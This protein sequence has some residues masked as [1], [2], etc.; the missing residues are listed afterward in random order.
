[1]SGRCPG[2]VRLRTGPFD[3]RLLSADIDAIARTRLSRA[4]GSQVMPDRAAHT[5]IAGID[6]GPKRSYGRSSR[7]GIDGVDTRRS[8]EPATSANTTARIGAAARA[9]PGRG[10]ERTS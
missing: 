5:L 10:V 1:M 6:Q 3:I 2:D 9:G 7:P 4:T 8:R